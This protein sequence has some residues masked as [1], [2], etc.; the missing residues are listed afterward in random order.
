MHHWLRAAS[1]C[2][3]LYTFFIVKISNFRALLG[4]KTPF[5]L[6]PLS[7]FV[8]ENRQLILIISKEENVILVIGCLP[9]CQFNNADKKKK[10]STGGQ[11]YAGGKLLQSLCQFTCSSHC[12]YMPGLFYTSHLCFQYIFILLFSLLCN[13]NCCTLQDR[14]TL[15]WRFRWGWENASKATLTAQCPLRLLTIWND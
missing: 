3:Y 4:W 1:N 9:S 5:D 7:L 11:R 8:L 10:K 2:N 13:V 15:M 14:V 6:C 12:N